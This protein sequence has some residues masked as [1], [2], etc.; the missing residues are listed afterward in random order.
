MVAGGLWLENAALI[1]G[2]TR[3]LSPGFAGFALLTRVEAVKQISV[4]ALSR[5]WL[6]AFTCH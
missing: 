6:P 1:R 2:E 3:S 4:H 5:N